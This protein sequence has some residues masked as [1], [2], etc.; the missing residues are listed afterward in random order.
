ELSSGYEQL[1]KVIWDRK[2][3]RL[4]GNTLIILNGTHID[5]LAGLDTTIK[6]GDR[7]TLLPFIAGG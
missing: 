4:L 6:V 5:L 3:R 2:T 1:E 7:V